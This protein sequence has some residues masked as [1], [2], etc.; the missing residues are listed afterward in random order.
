MRVRINS[1]RRQ[2]ILEGLPQ[3]L[4]ASHRWGFVESLDS[5]LPCLADE[6]IKLRLDSLLEFQV[7]LQ[8]L[9]NG[10]WVPQMLHQ[11]FLAFQELP[12]FDSLLGLTHANLDLGRCHAHRAV[13]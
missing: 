9:G 2:R 11:L 6:L 13:P 7:P 10:H 4:H 8:L 3:G 12:L 1:A 5:H